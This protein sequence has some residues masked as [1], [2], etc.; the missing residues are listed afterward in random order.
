[1]SLHRHAGLVPAS[2]VDPGLPLGDA[3]SR[4]A[5]GQGRKWI[6]AQRRNDETLSYIGRPCQSEA[7]VPVRLRLPSFDCAMKLRG[8]ATRLPNRRE[9]C[10]ASPGGYAA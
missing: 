3:R 9:T 7:M 5:S 8:P 2:A 4:R 1:M 10:E 6:P